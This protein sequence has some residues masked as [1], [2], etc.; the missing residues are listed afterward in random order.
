MIGSP[1]HMFGIY[2]GDES[3]FDQPDG[4]PTPYHRATGDVMAARSADGEPAYR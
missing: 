3:P 1:N 4:E 2:D